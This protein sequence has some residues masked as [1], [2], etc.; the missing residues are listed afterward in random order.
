MARSTPPMSWDLN[1]L[2]WLFRPDF[3]KIRDVKVWANAYGQIFYSMSICF[4][5]MI[6]YSSYLPR[7]SDIVNNAFM[8]GL[9]NCGFSMLAGIMIFSILGNMAASEGVPIKDV[10]SKGVGLA[11]VTI[12]KAISHLP[13]PGFFGV[14]FF[15]SLTIAVPT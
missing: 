9:L 10:V 11:F 14:L 2:D 6:T 12:P 3:S 8:T 7:K 13:A 4:A 1:G 15:L 5:I